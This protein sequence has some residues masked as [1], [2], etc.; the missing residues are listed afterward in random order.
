MEAEILN[1]ESRLGSG[2]KQ[3]V[4]AQEVGGGSRSGSIC[5]LKRITLQGQRQQPKKWRDLTNI[6]EF[7]LYYAARTFLNFWTCWLTCRC[8]G[9]I[10]SCRSPPHHQFARVHTVR[11]GC[12]IKAWSE[13]VAHVLAKKWGGHCRPYAAAPALRLC[14]K[15]CA[16]ML[17]ESFFCSSWQTESAETKAYWLLSETLRELFL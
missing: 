3:W 4:S 17:L 16:C 6:H 1:H 15:P 10:N 2:S 12:L 14:L 13:G 5:C 8:H 7:W 11:P 9:N